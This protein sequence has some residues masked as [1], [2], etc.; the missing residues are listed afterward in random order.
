M[1]GGESC[2][3][4]SVDTE[5]HASG[6]VDAFDVD[7]GGAFLDGGEED[8]VDELDDGGLT[9]DFL[10]VREVGDLL[11]D[12]GERGGVDVVVDL[13]DDEDVCGGEVRLEGGADVALRGGDE[14][15]A[16]VGEPLDFLDEEEVGGLGDGDGERAVDEEE[17]EDGVC[18]DELARELVGDSRVGDPRGELCVGDAVGLGERFDDL[19]FGDEVEV[20][21]DLAEESLLA[22]AALFG[23]RVL[24]LRAG[25]EPLLDEEL[26]ELEARLRRAGA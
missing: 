10:E 2:E 24:E 23:E 15:D 4:S 19:V 9:G 16:R 20:D 14:L 18:L 7:V 11:V 26:A 21:E 13:V 22:C 1:R 5:S 17:G 6:V 3:E 12:D 25:E 8:E